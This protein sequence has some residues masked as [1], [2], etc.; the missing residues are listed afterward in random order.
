ML[1]QAGAISVTLCRLCGSGTLLI[2]SGLCLYLWYYSQ[3]S[4]S[5]SDR[6]LPLLSCLNSSTSGLISCELFHFGNLRTVFT[7]LYICFFVF[8][9]VVVISSLCF[10]L[11]FYICRCFLAVLFTGSLGRPAYSNHEQVLSPYNSSICF[12]KCS[13]NFS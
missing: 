13:I 7:F 11:T 2:S 10:V 8:L 12:S 1:P 9:D 3:A 5:P 4:I 6:C